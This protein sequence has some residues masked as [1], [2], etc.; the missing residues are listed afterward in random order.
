MFTKLL[1]FKPVWVRSPQSKG[2]SWR[3]TAEIKASGPCCKH[4]H[5]YHSGGC[6]S[7]MLPALRS[8]HPQGTGHHPHGGRGLAL[9]I[10]WREQSVCEGTK[11]KCREA[12]VGWLRMPQTMTKSCFSM[13]CTQD[14]TPVQRSM[15]RDYQTPEAGYPGSGGDRGRE[16]GCLKKKTSTVKNITPHVWYDPLWM[17][18]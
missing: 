14:Y 9:T 8:T 5:A 18:F 7:N 10:P 12:R 15:E 4:T 17:T 16:K 11:A 6:C 13:V 3:D 1:L 2:S